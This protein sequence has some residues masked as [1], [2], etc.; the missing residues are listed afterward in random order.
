MRKLTPLI[1]VFLMLAGCDSSNAGYQ[2]AVNRKSG[3]FEAPAQRP[4]VKHDVDPL[5]VIDD[6]KAK[7]MMDSVSIVESAL[8]SP[9]S[10]KFFPAGDPLVTAIYDKTDNESTMMLMGTVDS[11]NRMGGLGR[12]SFTIFWRQPG[13]AGDSDGGWNLWQFKSIYFY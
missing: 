13:R 2:S 1:V 3:V 9:G 4:R 6:W 10:A 8:V 12:S 5:I 11:Q 7:A